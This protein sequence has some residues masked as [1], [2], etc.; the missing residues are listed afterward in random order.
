MTKHLEELKWAE[1]SHK[2]AKDNALEWMDDVIR[3]H[4]SERDE[5]RR[6][7]E[8][9]AEACD[10]ADRIATPV[11][12]LSW[13][14]SQIRQVGQNARVDLAVNHASAIAMTAAE[15]ATKQKNV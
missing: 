14:V 6:L 1:R 10:E 2:M 11:S 5:L 7:R 4:D 8:R 13:F 15:V 12:V 3:Q 9:F